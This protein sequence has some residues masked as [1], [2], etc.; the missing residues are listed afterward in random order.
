MKEKSFSIFSDRCWVDNQLLP[1]SIVVSKGRIARIVLGTSLQAAATFDYSGKVLMPGLIDP[2]V[3][4]NEPGRTEWEG[5]ETATNAA[6]AGGITTL[7]DMPLNSSP[8]T[9]NKESLDQKL[10]AAEGKLR[11]NCGFWAGAIDGNWNALQSALDAGCLG[12]KVFLTHSGIDEFPNIQFEQLDTIMEKLSPYSVPLLVHCELDVPGTD[13]ALIANPKSYA[14]YLASRPRSWE[15]KA[16]EKIIALCA[17]HQCRTHIV[18]LSSSDA[19]EMIWKAK[20]EDRLPL[21]VET[22]PHYLLF[23]AEGIPDANTLYKCAPPIRERANN[24]KLIL[25]LKEG[26]IDF[27]ATD[28]SPAPPDMKG[29]ETGNFATSWGGI[30][31]LQ[32]L[33]SAGW[34]A[35]KEEL[36]L[37]EFIPLVTTK[38]ASFLGLGSIKGKLEE[39]YDADFVIWD[40]DSSHTVEKAELWYR[41]RISPYV[42]LN[43]FGEVL[44]TFV[45]GF[46]VY[47]QDGQSKNVP[48]KTILRGV[49]SE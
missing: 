36:S 16:I 18:H 42:G 33:L 46:L 7:V 47:N 10:A 48:G 34:T 12:V 23:D 30:A 27:L 17:K 24:D 38:A 49:E 4:I 39:G 43:L 22:C 37:R 11:V 19:L 13:S 35:V 21:T 14:A 40:P 26:V 20:N 15:D 29:L 44:A 31:G 6:A 41:H 9:I 45:G 28:H 8:V 3:H 25:A 2:H 1:A 5:F 32:F